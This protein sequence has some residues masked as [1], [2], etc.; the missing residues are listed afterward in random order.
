MFQIKKNIDFE[1]QRA[2]M[3]KEQIARRGIKDSNVLNAMMKV[4]RHLFVPP[5]KQHMSYDDCPLPIG[6]GQTI[7]Q[8]YMVAVMTEYLEL[9]KNSKVLEIGTGSG[10]QTAILAEIAKEVYTIERIESLSLKAKK[11]L[12]K[13]GYKNIF[14]KIDDGSIGWEEKSPFDAIIVTAAAPEVP[15][16]LKKQIADSGTMVIPVGTRFTQS[17]KIIKRKGAAFLEQEAF[18][19]AFVPLIGQE[20]WSE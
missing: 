11:I 12:E 17:L 5:Y 3:V 20:G 14:F 13:L 19:C 8:P 4:P 10:Y 18:L 6:E 9:N 1:K 2:L 7:S 15:E 16:S